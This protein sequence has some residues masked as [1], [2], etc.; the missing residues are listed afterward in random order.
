MYLVGGGYLTDLFNLL[1]ILLLPIAA[2]R[3][4]GVEIATAPLGLG[5]FR[6]V[7][8]ERR[9]TDLLLGASLAVR[10]HS[11]LELCNRAGLRPRLSSDD[12]FR[13][14]EVID[15]KP[16]G[17]A[18]S[19]PRP[20][21]G[22]NVFDQHGSD[23]RE[24][25]RSWWI[26]FVRGLAKQP[27]DIEAFCFHANLL[28]DYSR[29]METFLAAGLDPSAVR[30]PLIDFRGACAQLADYDAIASAR[31]HGVVVGNVLG[32]ATFAVH[33]GDYYRNKMLSAARGFER[34]QTLDLA[35]VSAAEAVERV[36]SVVDGTRARGGP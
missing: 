32:K 22:I 23:R 14:A 13:A 11:S 8:A 27:L 33:D 36:T 17:D 9:T 29:A 5:P 15:F 25:N 31:F 26:D 10:D 35:G 1:E 7:K 24:E 3:A 16:A 30:E 6:S 2:A 20:R 18:R 19:R 4:S 28:S 21:I 34:S 12:G